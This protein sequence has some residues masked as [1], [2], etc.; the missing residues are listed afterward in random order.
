MALEPTRFVFDEQ[1]I[2]PAASR[3]HSSDNE[4]V[5]L[6]STRDSHGAQPTHPIL[7]ATTTRWSIA[8]RLTAEL[9][10]LGLPVTVI[11]PRGNPADALRGSAALLHYD[12]ITPLRALARAITLSGCRLIIACDDRVVGHLHALHARYPAL[13]PV[14]ERSIGAPDGYATIDSRLA[15]LEVAAAAGLRV[16]ETRAVPDHA[17]LVALARSMPFPW[18]MK[19]DGTWGGA[20]VVRVENLADARRG[21]R[22]LGRV[23]SAARALRQLLFFRNPYPLA[24]MPLAGRPR[25]SVQ[26]YVEGEPANILATAWQGALLGSVGFDVIRTQRCFGAST[27]LRVVDR[28]DMQHAARLIA[29]QLG[30]SGYFGLDFVIERETG[31]AYLI[32]LNPRTTQLGHLRLGPG[33]DLL[34]ALL[35]RASGQ[36]IPVTDRTR[37]RDVI[38]LFPEAL[39]SG[40]DLASL[41]G[42]YHDVPVSRPDLVRRLAGRRYAAAGMAAAEAEAVRA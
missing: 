35:E 39:A 2:A 27:V 24:A 1:G 15:L 18:V 36:A 7:V 10:D 20:G 31:A 22:R 33:R 9:T 3:L 12:A 16:P 34:G 4:G 17:A 26:R 30:L 8:A 23:V 32:E 6:G 42:A 29:Q 5:E 38:A 25:I 37:G 13:R 19:A 14:I 11:G 41:A 40:A 21:L 28:P